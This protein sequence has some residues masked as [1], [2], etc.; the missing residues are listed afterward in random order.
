MM[1]NNMIQNTD[2][3]ILLI[4]NLV[5]HKFSVTQKPKATNTIR[6]TNPKSAPESWRV[7]L[8][9]EEFFILCVASFFVLL[10]NQLNF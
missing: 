4:T 10:F 1:G 8:L 5:K 6:N 2:S 3:V 7:F 9:G